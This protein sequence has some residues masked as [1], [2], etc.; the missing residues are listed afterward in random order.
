M[1]EPVDDDAVA[2]FVQQHAL[3]TV[4]QIESARA[5]QAERAGSG[6]PV[7]LADA[8]VALGIVT[9]AQRDTL[10]QRLQAH[11]QSGIQQLLHYRLVRKLGEGAMGTVFLAEDVRHG[12]NVAVKV[13][14]RQHAANENF[15]R[16][17]QR[18]A[19][20]AGRLNHV[21]I[22]RAHS[23]GEDHGRHFYVMEYCEGE[24]LAARL[25][26][27]EVLTPD[28]ATAVVV[29]VARGLKYA[30]E[31]GLIHRDVKPANIMMAPNGVAKLLDFGLTKSVDTDD[32]SFR[33][34]SGVAMGTPHYISPEQARGERDVDGR[35]DIYS[36]GATFYHLITGDTPYHGSSAFEVVTKHLSEQ[37]PDPRDL[38]D[39]ISPGV[40]HVIR[41]MMAKKP[42]DRYKDCGELLD[43]LELVADGLDPRSRALD[44]NLSS[45][46]MLKGGP[47]HPA[48]PPRAVGATATHRRRQTTIHAPL[49][50]RLQIGLI[51]GGAAALVLILVLVLLLP[52]GRG[53]AR[54]APPAR[55]AAPPKPAAVGAS[56]ESPAEPGTAG[57]E[58]TARRRL[59]ELSEE[60]QKGAVPLEKTV[61]AFEAFVAS[62]GDTRAGPDA[63]AILSRLKAQLDRERSAAAAAAA[64]AAK[65]RVESGVWWEAESAV[66]HT[67]KNNPWMQDFDKTKLS[68]GAWLA[69]L[70][71]ANPN[72][73]LRAVYRVEV[74]ADA[75]YTLWV[76]EFWWSQDAVV[77]FRWDDKNW[78]EVGVMKPAVDGVELAKDR[79]LHWRCYG[80][81]Y[82]EKGPHTF[83]W[84]RNWRKLYAL[85]CFFL[86]RDEFVPSGAKRPAP[87]GESPR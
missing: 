59:V 80:S 85:D 40:V 33:T 83:T 74:P 73:P 22:A 71:D 75:V 20:A 12:R 84:L 41:R 21:N 53:G 15:M 16:R 76:R 46:A 39:G 49:S 72:T 28:E 42:G 31:L 61:A 69:H 4:A 60:E 67:F 19:D 55:P 36:L 54:K 87:K 70:D 52:G 68:G 43:D 34:Q 77:Q 66:E 79:G 86:T 27:G 45:V 50:R 5:F 62:F 48:P 65:E 81:R 47:R 9:P 51:A 11:R 57:R 63:Q 14:S 26:R 82:L 13:L 37:L 18:E 24:T 10:E 2:Q 56:R 7:S 25:K 78:Q 29:Q 64:P 38:Q 1:P 58:E 3:A 8:L 6:G 30:H 44:A 35:A 17:F 32:T 23:V